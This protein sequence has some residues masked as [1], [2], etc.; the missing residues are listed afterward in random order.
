MSSNPNLKRWQWIT[1]GSLFT[2]YAA[3]Y[4]CRSNL[5]V[6][7]PLLLAEYADRGLTKEGMGLIASA[8]VA[9]YAIGKVI[10]GLLADRLGGRVA[11]RRRRAGARNMER[12]LRRS[13]RRRRDRAD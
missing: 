5:S 7:T 10:N 2:G 9:T 13:D 8:G 3:Y 11:H 1:A 6:A 4:I 12:P